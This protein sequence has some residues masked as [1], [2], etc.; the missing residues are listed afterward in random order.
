LHYTITPLN[1]LLTQ[2]IKFKKHYNKVKT[3]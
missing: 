1:N 3:T 2:T